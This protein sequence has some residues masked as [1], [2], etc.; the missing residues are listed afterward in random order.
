VYDDAHT[1]LLDNRVFNGTAGYHVLT[2]LKIE[3]GQ[4]AILVNRGW[5]AVGRT[6]EEIPLPPAPAGKIRLE[7]MAADPRNRFF[8]LASTEP[9]GRVWQNL[10]FARFVTNYGSRLQPVLLL[11]T[12]ELDDGLRRNW[13]R[14]DTGVSMPI[15]D[16]F[17]APSGS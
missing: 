3:G 4:M 8:E 15:G 1:I 14:P 16:E 7:G 17:E 9:Q 5:V 13:P 2:P 11:Q 12:S 10:D 6:R